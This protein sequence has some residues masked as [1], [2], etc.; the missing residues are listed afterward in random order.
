MFKCEPENM[1]EIEMYDWLD[2]F[3]FIEESDEKETEELQKAGYRLW[4]IDGEE[5][6]I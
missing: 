2:L 5:F 3:D 4:V 6:P 1:T